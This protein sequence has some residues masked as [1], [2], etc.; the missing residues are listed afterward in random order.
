MPLAVYALAI[1]AFAICTTEFVIVGLLLNISNDLS[2]SISSSGMLVTAYAMGVVIGA[3]ILTPL[4]VKLKRKRALIVLMILYIVGNA[5]CALATSYQFLMLARVVAA[6]AQAS[7]FGLGAVVATQLVPENKQ[8]SAVAAMFLG[9]TLANVFGA[10]IGSI[11]G[12][13]FDWRSAFIAC[14]VIGFIAAVAIVAI[15]PNVKSEAPK[16][17]AQ[18]FTILLQPRAIKALLMTVLGFGGIFTALTYLGPFLTEATGFP[19]T[20]VSWLLFIFGVGMVIGNPLGGRMTDHSVRLALLVSLAAVIV[21]LL[22][23]SFFASSKIL[24]VILIFVFGAIMFSSIPPLQV[25]AMQATSEA[26][27]M[28]SSFNIAAFNLGNA[29][30]AWLG[31]YVLDHGMKVVELPIVAAAVTTFGLVFAYIVKAGS[32]VKAIS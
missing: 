2:I 13:Y 30:G 16:N 19:A 9:A 12:Q 28:G 7:F 27:V 22:S 6:L 31:A 4:M 29:G 24:T 10:P 8:A 32:P 21:V 15:V 14:S 18:E 17:I 5:A 25:Q 23:L 20:A 26:A 11:I 3:P 1:G